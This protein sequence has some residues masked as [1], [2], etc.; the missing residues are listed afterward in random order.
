[1]VAIPKIGEA[2]ERE[3]Q[4]P[5]NELGS[6]RLVSD[7]DIETPAV[8]EYQIDQVDRPEIVVWVR[9]PPTTGW[10]V[11]RVSSSASFVFLFNR[12]REVDRAR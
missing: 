2:Q 7:E 1:M 11:P 10:P 8:L 12:V 3:S 6:A 4:E 5:G 9:W